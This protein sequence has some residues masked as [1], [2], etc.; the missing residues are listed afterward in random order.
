MQTKVL[1]KG[2]QSLFLLMTMFDKNLRTN[3]IFIS[4]DIKRA[5]NLNFKILCE[6]KPNCEDGSS[7]KEMSKP[8]KEEEGHLHLLGKFVR[9]KKRLITSW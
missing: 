1:T 7:N 9:V 8:T 6:F 3:W 2:L 4:V 5:N